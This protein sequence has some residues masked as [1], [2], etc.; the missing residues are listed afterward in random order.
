M[1]RHRPLKEV[2]ADLRLSLEVME[3]HSHFGL[4]QQAAEELHKRI[5]D[6]IA[7]LE[8]EIAAEAARGVK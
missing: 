8:A 6:Q 3:E 5:L 4:D 1:I 7:K 2:L